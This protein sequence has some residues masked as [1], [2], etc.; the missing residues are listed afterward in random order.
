MTCSLSEIRRPSSRRFMPVS[1]KT[2]SPLLSPGA[3]GQNSDPELPRVTLLLK[4]ADPAV[5]LPSKLEESSR[6]ALTM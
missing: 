2:W 4:V 5:N 1:A 3:A 6:S